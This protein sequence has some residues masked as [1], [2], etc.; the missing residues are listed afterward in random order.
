MSRRLCRHSLS[1]IPVGFS[2]SIAF[3]AFLDQHQG[4]NDVASE[5]VTQTLPTERPRSVASLSTST[6][7]AGRWFRYRPQPEGHSAIGAIVKT[8]IGVAIGAAAFALG[9]QTLASVIWVVAAVIGIV[10]IGSQTMRSGVGR[11]FAALGH[12]LGWLLGVV[13]LTPLYL[14]GFTAARVLG[15]LAGRDPLHLRDRQAHTFWLPAD[16]DRRKVR[17]IRALYATET[18]LPARGWSVIALVSIAAL[19]ICAELLLRTLGFGNPMLYQPHVRAGYFPGPNQDVMRYGGRVATNAYGMRGPDFQPDKPDDT[20]RIFMIGDS[21]L[22]GGSFVD[23]PDLYA[24]RLDRALNAAYGARS[25]E[26]LNIAS[27]GWGPFN[28]LGY[29]ES[30]GTFESDI[31]VI[32]LPIGDIH[33]DLAQLWGVPYFPVGAP[34]RLALEEV[35]HHLNW[36]SRATAQAAP[37]ADELTATAERGIQAYVE[38][39]EMLRERGCEVLV[40]ILPSRTAGTTETVPEAEQQEVDQLRA[41]LEADGFAVGFPA[42]LFHGRGSTDELYRDPCHLR[43]L[44]HEIYAAYL[45]SRLGEHSAKLRAWAEAR[46]AANQVGAAAQ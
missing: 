6:L 10:T 2:R 41:V 20:L 22:Y 4:C 35:L 26:V 46:P 29:V 1:R 27:N 9:A 12:W 19:V 39:A 23:Q 15:R 36:R 24:R 13:L 25:V 44:G 43:T 7:K 8:L 21:T 11:F 14:I 32:C 42:G 28:K 38:L 40:E 17:H 37:S 16:Q 18:R 45:Q 3:P 31:A 5:N 30:F 33:R 34:P